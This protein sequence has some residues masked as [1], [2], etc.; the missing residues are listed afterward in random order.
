MRV[1]RGMNHKGDKKKVWWGD[2]AVLI[3]V[4]W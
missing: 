4:C 2:E 1:E 3:V